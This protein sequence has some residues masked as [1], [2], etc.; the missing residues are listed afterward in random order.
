MKAALSADLARD[1][2]AFL[3]RERALFGDLMLCDRPTPA[4]A[5]M[6]RAKIRPTESPDEPALFDT[7]I[8]PITR[9]AWGTSP[10]L[11]AMEAA[12]CDCVKCPLGH[13]RTK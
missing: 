12:T 7:V 1:V 9:E 13:T 10:T 3:A 11:E 6:P 4:E 5:T 8:A 2:R